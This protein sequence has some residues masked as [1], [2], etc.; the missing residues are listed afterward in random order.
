MKTANTLTGNDKHLNDWYYVSVN[1]A[2]EELRIYKDD[3]LANL[4]GIY[5][6]AD[7]CKVYGIYKDKVVTDNVSISDVDKNSQVRFS[8]NDDDQITALYLYIEK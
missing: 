3:A 8:V 5:D 7:G 4:E 1:Y 2:N 6:L